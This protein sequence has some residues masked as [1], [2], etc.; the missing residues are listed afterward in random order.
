MLNIAQTT[1]TVMSWFSG[2]DESP[3]GFCQNFDRDAHLL[4]G[5]EIWPDP[6]FLGWQIF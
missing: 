6:I 3:G 1:F 4:F 2:C 5:F